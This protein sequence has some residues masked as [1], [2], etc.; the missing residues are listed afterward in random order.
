MECHALSPHQNDDENE[1]LRWNQCVHQCVHPKDKWIACKHHL[2]WILLEIPF[3]FPIPKE[4]NPVGGRRRL[5]L[6][7]RNCIIQDDA[8][9]KDLDIQSDP[10]DSFQSQCKAPNVV[11]FVLGDS[12][13]ANAGSIPFGRHSG[14]TR[15]CLL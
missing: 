6:D 12:P 5:S 9:A 11:P 3:F 14:D 15:V 2:A 13:R 7:A 10:H 4:A 1:H 8:R